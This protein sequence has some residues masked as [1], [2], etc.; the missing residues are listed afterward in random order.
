MIFNKDTNIITATLDKILPSEVKSLNIYLGNSFCVPTSIDTI[1][2]SC[3]FDS[4]QPG[5]YTP[6]IN[7]ET[8]NLPN[9]PSVI[10]ITISFIITSVDP[11]TVN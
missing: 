7:L 5:T 8:G 9:N 3:T 1:N 11:Q 2:L 10:D 4:L 6:L